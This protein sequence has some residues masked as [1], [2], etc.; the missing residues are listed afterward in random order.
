[1]QA[2]FDQTQRA[3]RP[4]WTIFFE[5]VGPAIQKELGWD[6]WVN[7]LG[8]ILEKICD[9]NLVLLSLWMILKLL[10]HINLAIHSITQHLYYLNY[11]QRC[12]MQGW[13]WICGVGYSV[14]SESEV[15]HTVIIPNQLWN[16]QC[17]FRIS[18]VLYGVHSKGNS[19]KD[20]NALWYAALVRNPSC[21]LGEFENKFEHVLR[22]ESGAHIPGRLMQ[23]TRG[24]K[25]RPTVPLDR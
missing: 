16:R 3:N 2:N 22:C 24:W 20:F 1:M 4:L 10:Y 14:D 7:F 11:F 8:F 12:Q 23:K 5:V 19:V 9:K 13:F 18:T 25:L 6:Y 15:Y 21:R 17:W